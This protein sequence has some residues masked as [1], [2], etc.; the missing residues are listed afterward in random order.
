VTCPRNVH[1]DDRW[2]GLL[3]GVIAEAEIIRQDTSVGSRRTK[4]QTRLVYIVAESYRRVIGSHKLAQDAQE[5][6]EKDRR[7]LL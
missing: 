7:V 6:A 1:H 3:G 4:P 5:R 2:A